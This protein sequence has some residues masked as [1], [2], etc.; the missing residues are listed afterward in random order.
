MVKATAAQHIDMATN[1]FQRIAL[2]LLLAFIVPFA[3]ALGS[4]DLHFFLD[5]ME[6][7]CVMKISSNGVPHSKTSFDMV[8]TE[9][10]PSNSMW[11]S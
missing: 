8:P 6:S 3:K 11:T 7:G 5:D 9:M 4:D 1:H 2:T 10:L